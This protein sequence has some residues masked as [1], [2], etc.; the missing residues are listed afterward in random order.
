[1]DQRKER[2]FATT[3]MLQEIHDRYE[4]GEITREDHNDLC[5][6]ICNKL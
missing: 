3:C 5:F 2:D 1:M 6:K 4:R